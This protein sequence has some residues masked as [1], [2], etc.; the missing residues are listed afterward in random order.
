VLYDSEACT[1]GSRQFS[2]THRTW[3]TEFL[4]PFANPGT[5]AN[6]H[7]DDG[8]DAVSLNALAML[9]GLGLALDTRLYSGWVNNRMPI[10]S[11]VSMFSG[12][13]DQRHRWA[14]NKPSIIRLRGHSSMGNRPTDVQELRIKFGATQLAVSPQISNRAPNSHVGCPVSQS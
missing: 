13:L 7:A 1:A 9:C 8:G 5:T 11:M 12:H 10:G 3:A 4:L 6:A 14:S 2:A